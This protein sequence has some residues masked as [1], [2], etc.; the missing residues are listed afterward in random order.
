MKIALLASEGAPYAKSGGLG[1][2]MEALPAALARIEGNQVLLFLPYYKKI[3]QNPAYEV[4]LAAQF[5]VSLG[6]RQQYAGILR[7][8]NRT[9]GV[10]V[11]FV[12]N[13]YYFGDR[14][15]PIYGDADD[16]ERFA[17]YSKACLD[18]L[19]ALGF[20]PDVI[21]CN[22]WQT[23]LV[24]T[25]LAAQ[26]HPLFPGTK[27]M[28]T[29]HNVEYQGWANPDFFDN[30]LALPWEYRAC[31]DLGGG[32]NMMK[33]AV[34]TA[35][36]VT[37]VSETYSRQL[38]YPYYAHGMDGIL[39]NAAWKLTGITNGIDVNTF[40]PETDPALPAHYNADTFA[41]GKAR[42]KAAL[43]EEVGLP[44]KADV[45]LMVMVTRLAGHK[46]L[47]LLCHI[48]RRLLWERSCQLL[49]L[50]TGEPHFEQFFR[51]LAKEFPDQVAAKITFDLGLASRI[52][53]GGDV[54]LMPSKSEPCGLSQMNAMR[55][56]TVP[57]VHATGG[58]KDTVP[59]VDEKGE[60]GLGF[61]F[62]SYN[63]DD[64]HGALTRCLDLYD[65]N[66][67]AFRQLQHTCM[68]Q[69]FSWDKPAE[70]YMA[71]FRKMREE[72]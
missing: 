66:R 70:K 25:Y 2:V 13:L 72:M 58:L 37:T 40:N 53:A 28:F 51:D 36:L 6:W 3:R 71:L 57:V 33:G 26:Y 29:I 12:D 49:I 8:K 21:Q 17:F 46:G 41:Q 20:L 60:G 54:Y 23:A 59:P 69:D 50:G 39:S 9:D 61:T 65:H 15:G 34:E 64:F 27:C 67:E 19:V 4:E 38:M 5:H 7:L 43:Q 55:Y 1:D 62:Q 16:G 10:Q 42:C 14:N 22:D 56:G 31:L 52:Y 35:H 24:P 32:V 48:A 11:Y 63:A 18:G 47:D 45:P 44:V 30:V 68:A